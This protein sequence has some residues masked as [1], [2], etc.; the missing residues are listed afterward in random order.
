MLLADAAADPGT[1]TAALYGALGLVG[2]ALIGVVGNIIDR[3]RRPPDEKQN[4]VTQLAEYAADSNDR[5]EKLAIRLA[6][7]TSE[8]DA[9]KAR[10][11]TCEQREQP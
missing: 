3:H 7:V 11:E 8:R 10:A 1:A 5:A 6:V 2:V 9:W 4:V